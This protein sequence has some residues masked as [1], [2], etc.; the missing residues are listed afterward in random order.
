MKTAVSL[1]VFPRVIVPMVFVCST[2]IFTIG[3]DFK[4]ELKASGSI[5]SSLKVNSDGAGKKEGEENLTKQ[6]EMSICQC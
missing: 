5:P 2:V 1:R 3:C 4:P 6:T